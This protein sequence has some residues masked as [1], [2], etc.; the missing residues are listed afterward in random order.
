MKKLFPILAVLMLISTACQLGGG[1]QPTPIAVSTA[2][3]TSTPIALNATAAPSGNQSAGSTRTSTDGMTEVYIPA[4]AFQM[5]GMDP[6]ASD[7]EKPVHK[8]TMPSFWIDKF[9]VTNAMYLG[10]V[11]KGVCTPPQALTSETRTSYFNDPNYN[12]YPVIEVTWGQADA[13]C[14]WAGRHLPTEAEWE[15]AGRGSTVNTYPWGN[16]A[17]D[18]TL[19]NFDRQSGDTTKVGSYP[20]GASPFGV[21]DMAGN[22]TQWVNDYY[23]GTY[24]SKG[25]NVNPP[26]P[27]VHPN[28][29]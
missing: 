4:G 3:P 29:F 21:L 19:A 26:G 12:D 8:V 13:Y 18:N 20:A 17:P 15:Y 23:D 6:N 1:T 24:Y 11:N 28:Y 2:I 14:K 10:C 5:G 27:G 22:V 25:M 7:V 16:Q 9:D